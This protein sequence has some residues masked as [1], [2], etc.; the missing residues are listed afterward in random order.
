MEA[1]SPNLSLEL[2]GIVSGQQP[3]RHFTHCESCCCCL[4][5]VG[6]PADAAAGSSIA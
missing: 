4:G 2:S 1:L 3:E 5:S 6:F